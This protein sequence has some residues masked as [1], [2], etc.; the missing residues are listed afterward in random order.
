MRVLLELRLFVEGAEKVNFDLCML[1]MTS[2]D[3]REVRQGEEED[4][5]H[6]Q[7]GVDEEC[8]VGRPQHDRCTTASSVRNAPTSRADVVLGS[9]RSSSSG[10]WGL[11]QGA[12]VDGGTRWLQGDHDEVAG[13]HRDQR[14]PNYRA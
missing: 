13:F 1:E 3:E 8:R 5:H 12:Q 10:T 9:W 2:A 6:E 14:N 11:R 7:L 4:E